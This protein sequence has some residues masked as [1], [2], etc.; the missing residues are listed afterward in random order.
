MKEHWHA[1]YED[2]L[3]ALNEP[4]L[5]ALPPA[6]ETARIYDVHRGWLK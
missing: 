1:G 4:S 2:A 6:S 5:R 3:I